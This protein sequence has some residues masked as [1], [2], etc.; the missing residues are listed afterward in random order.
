[1]E[2]FKSKDHLGRYSISRSGHEPMPEEDERNMK[3]VKER[4]RSNKKRRSVI[5]KAHMK[6]LRVHLT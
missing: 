5:G 6:L 2:Q 4:N 1:M 3:R